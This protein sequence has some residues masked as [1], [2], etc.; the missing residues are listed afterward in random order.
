MIQ[1]LQSGFQ[2]RNQQE[3]PFNTEQQ[4]QLDTPIANSA[5]LR[6]LLPHRQALT[7]GELVELLQH[8]QLETNLSK[9]LSS[10]TEDNTSR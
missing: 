4:L 2:N 7:I 1:L 6:S 5:L 9:E 8:D 3:S 10:S